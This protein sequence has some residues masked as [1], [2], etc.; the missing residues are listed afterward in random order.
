MTDINRQFNEM[1]CPAVEQGIGLNT[2]ELV[3]GNIGSS[4]RTKYGAVGSNVNLTA[5]IESYALGGQILVSE[6]TLAVC[7]PVLRIDRS[8]EVRPKGVRDP[9]TINEVGGIGGGFNLYLP[10]KRQD[11]MVELSRRL[12]ARFSIFD[13]KHA[14]EELFEGSVAKLGPSAAI[15]HPSLSVER[16]INIKLSII[17]PV[18]GDSAADMYGKIT[19]CD[20]QS[21]HVFKVN[22][23]YVS[24]EARPRS[25][26]SSTRL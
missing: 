11:E 22:F 5:R 14:T 16:W 23:S 6:S 20:P 8:M 2:G 25:M 19:E 13:G 24:N 18:S 1:G 21:A 15:I 7:G 17:D 12:D 3:V 26:S 10:G 9:I 4:K